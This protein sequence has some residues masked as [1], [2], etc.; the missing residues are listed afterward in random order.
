MKGTRSAPLIL[1]TALLVFRGI[2]RGSSPAGSP[3]PQ[4][5]QA[6]SPRR[7]KT[8]TRLSTFLIAFGGPLALLAGTGGAT[9]WFMDA[10][11]DSLK[12]PDSIQGAAV[13]ALVIVAVTFVSAILLSA[14]LWMFPEQG[15]ADLFQT[16]RR[17]VARALLVFA[18]VVGAAAVAALIM[19]ASAIRVKERE[20]GDSGQA[21]GSVA[22]FQMVISIAA[23]AMSAPIVIERS[24]TNLLQGH[25]C[26]AKT[27]K[28]VCLPSAM[29]AAPLFLIA[30][31]GSDVWEAA[32][33]AALAFAAAAVHR[34]W[35]ER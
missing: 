27:W 18:K 12:P 8:P 1:L 3:P 2:P 5:G 31:A 14:C 9:W 10:N 30:L 26:M 32:L 15:R 23:L 20:W 4:P 35:R 16:Q 28:R 6:P 7:G 21:L 34:W 19:A 24:V 33:I 13:F 25:P 17:E 29:V 11:G 22:E